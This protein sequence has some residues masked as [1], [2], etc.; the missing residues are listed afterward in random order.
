MLLAAEVNAVSGYAVS[1]S[2]FQNSGVSMQSC[3]G[4]GVQSAGVGICTA[5]TLSKILLLSV[6]KK[7][8][9]TVYVKRQCASFYGGKRDLDI[10]PAFCQVALFN[11]FI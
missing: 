3:A 1:W 11:S 2:G 8:Y 7:I 5:S 10:S 4:G 9:R 6:S